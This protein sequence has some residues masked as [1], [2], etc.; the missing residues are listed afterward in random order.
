MDSQKRFVKPFLLALALHVV[1]FSLFAL[2]FDTKPKQSSEPAPEIIQASLEEID[3]PPE[4]ETQ[5]EKQ[6]DSRAE[7]QKAAELKRQQLAEQQKA[8]A[9]KAAAEKAESERVV[10]AEKARLRRPRPRRLS[11]GRG[12][13]AAKARAN[14]KS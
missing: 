3:V 9:A 4:A 11:G 5:P 2:S 8:E 12:S 1:L 14:G 7:Q 13:E 10:A 6:K